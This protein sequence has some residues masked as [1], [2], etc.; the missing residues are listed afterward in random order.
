MKELSVDQID[1]RILSDTEAIIEFC[2]KTGT[3]FFPRN[4]VALGGTNFHV[5]HL[6]APAR[7]KSIIIPYSVHTIF[8]S[9]AHT[10]R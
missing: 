1:Y 5:A 10:A 4:C 3:T 7:V 8:C 9:N 2:S 6:I